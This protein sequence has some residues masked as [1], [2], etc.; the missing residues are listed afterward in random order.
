MNEETSYEASQEI[1]D[2]HLLVAAKQATGFISLR[3]AGTL[4]G[5][6]WNV[7]IARLLGAELLGVF[8]LGSTTALFVALVSSLGVGPMLVR[9][10]PVLMARGDRT[11][12]A[13]IFRFGTR[14]VIASSVVVAVLVL[15][16]RNIVAGPIF[17]E[18]KLLPYMPIVAAAVIPHAL[19]ILY[20]Y[21]LR[22]CKSAAL[23]SLSRE[24]IYKIA[25]VAVFAGLFAVGMRLRGLMIAFVVANAVTAAVMVVFVQRR[26]PYLIKGPSTPSIPRREL[27][28]FSTTMLFV[29][30]MNYT[31]GI[32]D[33]FMLGILGTSENVGIY[34]VAFLISN[35]LATVTMGF[36]AIFS[37][38]ISELYHDNKRGELRAMF[39]SLTRTIILIVAPAFIWLVGFGDDLLRMFGHEFTAGYTALVILG[40]SA[41]ASCT[42]GSV[43]MML[44]MT[45]HQKYN[46]VNTVVATGVNILLN[47]FF[48][49]R[50]GI[51]GAALGN[52]ISLA[53]IN[54]VRMLQ[55][56][57]L[58]G[59]H[60]Y[61]RSYLKLVA[62][63]LVT[64]A[65]ALYLRSVTPELGLAA[66]VGILVATMGVFVG[67]IALLGIERDDRL[68]LG[69]VVDKLGIRRFLKRRP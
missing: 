48:I 3:F 9:Y 52:G 42:V 7:V 46:V 13:G 59:I 25:L 15:L 56:H 67:V 65:G 12:A 28:G 32:T 41:V 44:A 14:V 45:G 10:L 31:M 19:L 69:R 1:T 57:R 22:A 27:L 35:L 33:R 20:G 24:V 29:A 43:S 21:A 47:W 30:F 61:N 54:V 53:A 4:I 62:A 2:R 26:A 36:N 50:C 23:E 5:L 64:L 55:V 18:P 37:P 58:L 17:H 38:I 8:V 34:N 40:L 39:A 60:P 49:P 51:V 63:G 16:G 6:G 66:I 11:G 68:I